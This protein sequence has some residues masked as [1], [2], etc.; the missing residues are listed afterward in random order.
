MGNDYVVGEVLI[1]P[2][3]IDNYAVV[4]PVLRAL[5]IFKQRFYYEGKNIRIT[6]VCD[7]AGVAPPSLPGGLLVKVRT[8]QVWSIEANR[9]LQARG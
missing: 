6:R 7:T 5:A 4:L 9:W 2:F 3:L 8:S 1:F